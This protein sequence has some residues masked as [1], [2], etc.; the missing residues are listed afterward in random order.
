MSSPPV[1]SPLSLREGQCMS[2]SPGISQ[3]ILQDM[4][5]VGYGGLP[6][7]PYHLVRAEEADRRTAHGADVSLSSSNPPEPCPRLAQRRTATVSR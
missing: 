2:P 6:P 5:G 7:Y 4:R 3:L 1:Q